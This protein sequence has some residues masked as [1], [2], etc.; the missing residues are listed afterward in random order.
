MT[1][2]SALLHD[3]GVLVD[4][5]LFMGDFQDLL[6]EAMNDGLPLDKMEQRIQAPA[7]FNR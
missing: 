1:G 7:S 2:S 5:I 3:I 6:K 4:G